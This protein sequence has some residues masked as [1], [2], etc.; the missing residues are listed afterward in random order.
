MAAVKGFS[1]R[2]RGKRLFSI[3]IPNIFLYLFLGLMVAF[4]ALPLIYVIS[5]AFKPLDELF[6]YPPKFFVRRPTLEN[7]SDLFSAFDNTAV[8]FSRNIFNS[9]FITIATVAVTVVMSAMA[10]YG[11]VKQKPK[12]SGFIFTLILTAL[13]FSPHVTQ[14]PNYVIVKGLHLID[15]YWALILPKIAVAYNVFLMKQFLEQMPDALL[16]A[17]RLDGANEWQAFWRIVMPYLK[18]AW[19]TLVVFSFVSNW[20]DYFSPLVFTTSESM[21]TLPLA[22]QSI[23]GGPGAAALSTMGA[24]AASTLLMTLPTIVVYTLMQGRVLKTMGYSGIKS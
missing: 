23:A 5:S 13:M 9:L 16:E 8:P 20:N 7:F 4:T 15:T 21:K 18:P 1:V 17:A 14:I 24:M 12:G 11:L 10:A 3:Y 6:L 2:F 22:V 19:A